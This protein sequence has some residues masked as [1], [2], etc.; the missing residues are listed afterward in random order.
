VGV[1]GRFVHLYLNGLY[2]GLYNLVERPND[3]FQAS[4]FGG[5]K[6][7]WYVV[8][9]SGT[10]SG[11][12]DRFK[13]LLELAEG[14][15]LAEPEKYAQ[16]NSLLDVPQFVDY[17]ILE[18]YGGNTDWPQ[19]NWYAAVQNPTGQVRYFAWDGE[20][21][22]VEGAKVHTG[23]TNAVGLTNTIK[24]L[25]EA[26]IQNPDFKMLLADRVYH[27]LFNNG[28]LTDANAQ[29]RWLHLANEVEPAMVA[30]SARWGD[31]RYDDPITPADWQQ[32]RDK[33]LA[34]M[35]GNGAKLIGQLRELGYYPAID[36]PTFNQQGGLVEKGF[37]VSL[38]PPSFKEGGRGEVYYTVDGSDPRQ[39]LSGAVAPTAQIYRSPLVL[40]ATTQLK[41]RSYVNGTWS[42][43]NQATFKVV[44]Q[45]SQMAITEIMYNPLGGNDYEFIELKNVGQGEMNLAGMYFEAGISYT[46]PPGVPPLAPGGF[47]VLVHNPAAFASRYPGVVIGGVYQGK[48][49][50]QGE[51]LTLRAANGPVLLELDYDDE[52]G[53]P[54]SPDGRGD[55]LV[56]V[57][58]L[59]DPANPF[60]WRASFNVYGS[61]GRGE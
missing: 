39:P 47:M 9:H 56:L 53:W 5:E 42:A 34:Q 3:A 24:P 30:E 14:G 54:L 23:Q 27:H 43:L 11:A 15:N 26:L 60:S 51:K 17:L 1:H 41:T 58:P 4:Y 38:S 31:A 49:S 33:V 40:T 20:L 16:V 32:A 19:N 6:E 8:S 10:L 44:E 25:F 50:N 55:S 61:P 57:D 22:W 12:S 21:T 18:W 48:L 7:D 52:N 13:E 28:A 46:F 35:E 2:W 37:T 45:K 59:A 36:P 29:A